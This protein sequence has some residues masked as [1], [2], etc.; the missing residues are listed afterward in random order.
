[1]NTVVE[2]KMSLFGSIFWLLKCL[3]CGF[4]SSRATG[5]CIDII[6]EI[7]FSGVMSAAHNILSHGNYKTVLGPC[8]D[9]MAS[10]LSML[11]L[12]ISPIQT[13]AVNM[14]VFW[15]FGCNTIFLKTAP[16]G[17]EIWFTTKIFLHEGYSI[18]LNFADGAV[19]GTVYIE[20]ELQHNLFWDLEV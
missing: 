13:V 11:V 6:F 9:I 12:W 3:K 18:K 10:V 15:K 5:N 16:M 7:E 1:M 19:P 4:F 8:C 20:K 2:V 17:P 14:W